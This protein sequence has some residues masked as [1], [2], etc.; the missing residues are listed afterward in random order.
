MNALFRI[1]AVIGTMTA[2]AAPGHAWAEPE[3]MRPVDT[4]SF[5]SAALG[6]GAGA[7]ASDVEPVTPFQSI[8]DFAVQVSGVEGLSFTTQMMSVA[9]PTS[10]VLLCA[11]VGGILLGRR[12]SSRGTDS[13]EG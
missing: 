4:I 8:A 2:T 7:G 13:D 3:P 5:L 10:L 6:A 11:G 12:R 9:E 1:V